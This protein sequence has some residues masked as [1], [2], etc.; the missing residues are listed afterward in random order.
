MD[1]AKG[2]ESKA[3]RDWCSDHGVILEVAAAESHNWL[4]VV[5]RRHQDVR[6][7]LELYVDNVERGANIARLKEAVTYVPSRVNQFSFTKGQGLHSSPMGLGQ[8]HSTGH[9]PHGR[10]L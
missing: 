4:G 10:G 6:R 9:E 3:V 8:I 7:A 1:S 2:W 5:E